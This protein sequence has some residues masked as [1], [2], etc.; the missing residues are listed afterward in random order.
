MRLDVEQHFF[1]CEQLLERQR[2]KEF[3]HRIVTGEENGYITITLT[4][5]RAENH[6]DCPVVTLLRQ[7]LGR[8]SM[9]QN[10]SFALD[11]SSGQC[12]Y[13]SKIRTRYDLQARFSR[14]PGREFTLTS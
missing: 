7:H 2:G 8:I 1:A 14:I 11:I 3:L 5:G 13:K 10:S 4:Q 9:A 6:G 12:A